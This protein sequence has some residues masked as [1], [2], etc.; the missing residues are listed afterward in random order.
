MPI[1]PNSIAVGKSNITATKH[2][3]R[4]LEV[5]DERVRYAYGGSDAGGAGQWRWQTKSKFATDAA[6]EIS[7]DEAL[8][9]T[10]ARTENLEVFGF[11][12]RYTQKR[13]AIGRCHRADNRRCSYVAA[14]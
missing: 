9:Q 6:G 1:D 4:V 11:N 7:S 12:C 10:P 5:T 13:R 3:R 2:L 14:G 8:P